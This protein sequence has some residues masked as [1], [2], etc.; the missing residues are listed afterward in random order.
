MTHLLTHSI[1]HPFTYSLTH[2]FT[3]SLTHS[4]TYSLNYLIKTRFVE[5]PLVSPW[6]A[7]YILYPGL[8]HELIQNQ[9]KYRELAK[10]K[11]AKGRKYGGANLHK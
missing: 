10:N 6:S 11:I 5:Q 2:L 7:N 4:L 3:H 1:T 8:T 9:T